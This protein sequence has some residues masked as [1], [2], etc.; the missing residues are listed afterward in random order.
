MLER[1]GIDRA[2]FAGIVVG[3]R[4]E[5]WLWLAGERTWEQCCS[6]LDRPHRAPPPVSHAGLADP[7]TAGPGTALRLCRGV[8]G[9]CR[10]GAADPR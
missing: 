5:L 2:D 6:G 1:A 8:L 9:A 10:D 7:R 3:Y 4:R